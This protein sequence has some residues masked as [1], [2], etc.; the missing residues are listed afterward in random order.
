M[1]TKSRVAASVVAVCLWIVVAVL[2]QIPATSIFEA[3]FR[4]MQASEFKAM[5][6]PDS[7]VGTPLGR[8][9]EWRHDGFAIPL[10]V[11]ELLPRGNGGCDR[12]D[13]PV[14]IGVP[15]PDDAAIADVAE[16]RVVGVD[17]YQLR[18]LGYWESG[19]LK[20][21]LV[22]FLATVRAG[23][24][25]DGIF[26]TRTDEP[27]PAGR[28]ATEVDDRILLDT[29]AMRMLLARDGTGFIRQVEVGGKKIVDAADA[30]T[31]SA[32]GL[33]GTEYPATVDPGM[34][35]SVVENGPVKAVVKAVGTHRSAAG[36]ALMDFELR[37]TVFRGQAFA[38]CEYT[39]KNGSKEYRRHVRHGG[40]RMRL[41]TELGSGKSV[42][43]PRHG[44]PSEVHEGLAAG[45]DA[46]YYCAYNASNQIGGKSVRRAAPND[47]WVPAV[48]FNWSTGAY[49][50]E[51]Y[52][53]VK[54]G[55]PIVPQTTAGEFSEI[56][57]AHLQDSSGS[58]VSG[59]IRFAPR[60]WPISYSV[61]GDGAIEIGLFSDKVNGAHTVNF[62]QHE[63]REFSLDFTGHGASPYWHAF[64][65][66]FPLMARVT[67]MHYVNS[68][69]VISDKLVTLDEQNRFFDEYGIDIDIEPKNEAFYIVRFWDAGQGGGF[70]QLDVTYHN[71][72]RY[73][74]TGDTG[75]YLQAKA[76]A[77]YR[78]DW[79]VVHSDDWVHATN[80]DRRFPQYGAENDHEFLAARGHIFDNQHRHSRGLPL[81]YYFTGNER[82]RDA[83]LEDVE[84]VAFNDRVSFGYLNTRI[85]AMLLKN[86]MLGYQFLG[87]VDPLIRFAETGPFDRDEV[88]ANISGYMRKILDAR[89]D[90]SKACSGVHPKGWSD[91][92]GLSVNDHRRF[93]FAGGDRV[94]NQEPKFHLYS[95][96]P[97]AL[98][99]YA[100]H[101]GESDPAI[102][103]IHMRVLDLEHYFWDY[104]FSPCREVPEQSTIG[105]YYV[106]LFD[107]DC[108]EPPTPE[109][110][111]GDD[112]HPAYA[113]EAFAYRVTGDRRYLERGR[114]F[115]L[116][117]HY[118]SRQLG[119]FNMHR[120]DFLNFVYQHLEREPDHTPPATR[121]LRS[122]K[123]Q[124]Y[125][126][127]IKWETDE[128]A[129]GRVVYWADREAPLVTRLERDLEERHVM[130]LEGLKPLRE[131]KYRVANRDGSGNWSLSGRKL[132][133]YD[134]FS[135]DT[136]ANYSIE[137]R[138]GGSVAYAERARALR[139]KGAVGSKAAARLERR[140]GGERGAV[141]F[142]FLPGESHGPAS[143][144]TV[145]LMEDEDTYYELTAYSP[146]GDISGMRLRKVV[147]GRILKSRRSD[148]N[149]FAREG[150]HMRMRFRRMGFGVE[151]RGSGEIFGL[152]T[153]EASPIDVR[154]VG[155][156]LHQL[157]GW[158]DNLL[159]ELDG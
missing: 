122:V 152:N 70:N 26:V 108:N 153:P 49:V 159:I 33:D 31:L 16:L 60:Y 79:A 37:L 65:E 103:E 134:D 144:F 113:L 69:N 84:T 1:P 119:N 118:A 100:F 17:H 13:E 3:R 48:D 76:W 142:D 12:I 112:F 111:V 123:A 127:A 81:M 23:A 71:L 125:P 117:Q 137:T 24:S 75:A 133:G 10:S 91:E 39:L 136:V 54:N 78:A 28:L 19:H 140:S 18:P 27:T 90:M 82:Y 42:R 115:M 63:T 25:L 148:R 106:Y 30:F 38:R 2:V 61:E 86:G 57:F 7:G 51:G 156:V 93:W 62:L 8:L 40:I 145:L 95:M 72:I 138:Q 20:W 11:Q 116:G 157:G 14:S 141:S 45:D 80:G 50:E 64:K 126:V 149:P 66:T 34:R 55:V 107:G 87:E 128:P 96:F 22:D 41:E 99:N 147:D 53:I 83:F 6:Q 36:E 88:R 5:L 129:Q 44:S 68:C 85:Q 105:D 139:F 158:V 46:Y 109:C 104:L 4:S 154:S 67:D 59:S 52:R 43:F 92:P 58:A 47:G 150:L 101:V 73:W 114:H 97:D 77:D 130:A 15:I 131:Y 102:D 94:R 132:F 9:D 121:A 56:T 35:L 110:S 89:Y 98:W 120:T 135:R 143:S 124:E 74:R 29:G 151:E 32:L 146:E 155:I 21:V